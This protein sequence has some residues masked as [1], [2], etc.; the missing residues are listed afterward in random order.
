MSIIDSE[1]YNEL[2]PPALSSGWNYTSGL[3]GVAW[4]TS[5]SAPTGSVSGGNSIT[6]NLANVNIGINYYGIY[7]TKDNNNGNVIVS[8]TSI[9]PSSG[10]ISGISSEFYVAGRCP[11]NSAANGYV[12][13]F[14]FAGVGASYTNVVEILTSVGGTSLGMI[15]SSLSTDVWYNQFLYMFDNFISAYVQ[16]LSDSKWLAPN[17]AF[18]SV[19]QSCITVSDST[20]EGSGYAG[21]AGGSAGTTNPG[22]YADDFLFQTYP[23][24]AIPKNLFSGQI[25]T[26]GR[27][28]AQTAILTGGMMQ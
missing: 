26:T 4:E 21:I 7:G 11:S 23:V 12:L 24:P 28:R 6:L 1:N 17:G 18:S 8:S 10:L 9:F 22:F 20:H 27:M 2:T 5:G 25:L 13:Q 15:S 16:R 14:S 19:F 3:Y